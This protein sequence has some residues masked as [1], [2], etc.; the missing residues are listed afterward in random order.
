M[1]INLSNE[2][3]SNRVFW[4][5]RRD[6]QYPLDLRVSVDIGRFDGTL[7][8]EVTLE[9]RWIVFDKNDN[10]LQTHISIIHE[11]VKGQT[12][13]ALV[14]AMNNALTKLSLEIAQAAKK[15]I[16]K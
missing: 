3:S 2:L 15:H 9:T 6:R 13:E 16:K 1:V 11:P 12:Y 10:P 14:I 5:P 8:K 7:G 4:L